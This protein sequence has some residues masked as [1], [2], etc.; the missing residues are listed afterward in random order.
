MR[1]R[2]FRGYCYD[3]A[4]VGPMSSVV[5]PPYDQIGPETQALLYDLSPWNIVRVT[6][7]RDG[8]AAARATLDEW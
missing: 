2:P 4:R 3:P 7:P 8:Y 5:A 1:I 6:L